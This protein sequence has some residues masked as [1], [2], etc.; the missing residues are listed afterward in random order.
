MDGFPYSPREG[1]I[2]FCQLVRS[3]VMRGTNLVL[4]SGTGT[5]KTVCSLVG[6]LAEAMAHGRKV[7][8]LT[9]TNSQQRQVMLEMRQLAPSL[10]AFAMGVQGRKSSCPVARDDPELSSGSPDELSRMCQERK[11]RAMSGEGKGCPFY[12]A[13]REVDTASLLTWCRSELPTVEGFIEHCED[14]GLCPYEMMKEMVAYAHVVTAPYAYFF[15]PFIRDRFL[16]WLNIP[17]T[18]VILV[19]DEAHNLPEYA[20]E[21]NTLTASDRM[22]SM[23]DREIDDFGDPEVKE[24]VSARDLNQSMMGLLDVAQAEYLLDED[25]LIPPDFIV[26]GLMTD[27]RTTS[28]S[29]GAM[30]ND[31]MV[32]GDVVRESKRRM[33]RLPRSHMHSL[34]AFLTYWMQ[35]D[36]EHH[37]R[38]IIGGDNPSFQSYCLDPSIAAGAMRDS[39]AT[40]SM[41]GTL[42]PMEE[43]RDSL[44]LPQDTMMR[45]MASPFPPENRRVVHVPGVTTRYEVM[46]RDP[47][48]RRRIADQIVELAN[49]VDVNTMVFFPSHTLM[50]SMAHR[51]VPDIRHRVSIERRGMSQSELMDT[52]TRFSEH[53]DTVMFAVMGGRV[54]EGMDF[55]GDALELAVLVGIPYPK[56]TARQRALMHYN[57]LRF[58]RGWDYTVKV[59]AV[60]RMQQAIGRLIRSEQDRGMAV[61]LDERAKRFS[62]LL[63]ST[64]CQ[65]P[66]AEVKAFLD[67]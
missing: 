46:T 12:K 8:Y 18:D 24:G 10:G 34:G 37:V 48:A 23:V 6:A 31:L 63:G 56:P 7:V 28:H 41:S 16:G 15:V 43:Y 36:E 4:E 50:E 53:R 61:I 65:D 55:P 9:R 13:T 25:G 62:E 30:A 14:R 52:V 67:G 60:R 45:H 21:I 42:T 5:G 51:C 26:E 2:Q 66:V 39:H 19:I 64:P 22:L 44:G 59:P 1:Q 32:Y 54:A 29:L 20:R 38:L 3:T 47:E 17:M 35:M 57:D 40:V 27:F 11:R 58:G 49:A 33:G